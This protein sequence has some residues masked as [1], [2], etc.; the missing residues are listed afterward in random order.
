VQYVIVVEKNFFVNFVNIVF[1]DYCEIVAAFSLIV[2]TFFAE[3][4][5]LLVTLSLTITITIDYHSP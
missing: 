3:S 4:F 2:L 1:I 5:A